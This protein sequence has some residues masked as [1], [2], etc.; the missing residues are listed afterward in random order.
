M[1]SSTHEFEQT[2]VHGEGQGNLACCSP[3]DCKALDS[4]EQL[5][6]NNSE[7]RSKEEEGEKG[8]I[9]RNQNQKNGNMSMKV[10]A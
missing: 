2:S 5:N 1:A 8:T 9:K 4:N 3:W 6:N 10:K 7:K